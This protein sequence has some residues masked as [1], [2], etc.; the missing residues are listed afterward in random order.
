MRVRELM[1]KSPITIDPE[2]PIAT[3]VAS[4]QG[5][6]IRHLL[7]VDTA[8]AL[9]GIVSDRDLRDATLAPV[10][11]EY[12][13]VSARRRLRGISQTLADLRIRDVM[14]WGVVTVPPDASAEQAAAM[15]FERHIGA[16]PVIDR[17]KLVGIVTERDVLR[18]LVAKIPS[19]REHAF[20]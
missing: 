8:G 5:R 16:L 2:A 3:A 10:F 9:L 12:L 17:G 13:S 1:T 14:T 19:V 20:W 4:M 11:A 7:V 18:E 6:S 15:M